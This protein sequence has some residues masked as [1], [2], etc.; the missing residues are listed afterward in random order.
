VARLLK[1]RYRLI[2]V[3]GRGGMGVVWRALDERIDREVAVKLL[4]PWIAEDPEARV[5]FDREARALAQLTHNNI[6]RLYDFDKSG[7]DA[8]LVMELIEGK[9]LDDYTDG[10]LPLTDHYACELLAPVAEALRYAHA[11]GIVH[12]DLKPGNILVDT[13]G[14]VVV[15]DFGLA[16]LA[17]GTHS[18]TAT[19]VLIGSPEYWAP[20][21]A[22]GRPITPASDVYALGCLL[23]QLVTGR[24]PFEGED[25]LAVGYRR[26]H[27]DAPDPRQYVP[28]LSG[29][30]VAA[31]ERLL[32][33]EP[34][35]RPSADDALAFLRNPDG[36]EL[37]TVR[38]RRG[39]EALLPRE[40]LPTQIAKE[41]RRRRPYGWLVGVGAASVLLAGG[42]L[43]FALTRNHRESGTVTRVE[44]RVRTKP[45]PV[46][47]RT[48]VVTKSAPL[49]RQAA[50]PT[51]SLDRFDGTYFSV[52]YPAGWHVDTAEEWKN[53]VYMD[54]TIRQPNDFNTYL[55]VDVTPDIGTQ[56]P[57]VAARQVEGALRRSSSYRPL[58]FSR[59]VFNG[60]N[61]IRWEFTNTEGGVAL[62]KVDTFFIDGA[63]NGIAI[64]TQAPVSRF[65]QYKTLFDKVRASLSTS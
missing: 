35:E 18:I 57:L 36:A 34:E 14:R 2:E 15:S 26:V 22:S 9:S 4:H 45:G 59:S 5:R 61:A 50:P 43:A 10:A 23:Y 19:G 51:S 27:E 64:L 49:P 42:S 40:T 16:R 38:T 47:R 46:E 48:V 8:Y 28:G 24:L 63:G 55:R 30:I 3:I 41:V 52:G 58:D 7:R 6:V 39:E 25:R 65:G 53:G 32:A 56:D 31:L 21:Q 29:G 12:R 44:K 33:R 54:T 37:S 11:K 60:Y 20:E 13:A 17:E 1:K 62:R